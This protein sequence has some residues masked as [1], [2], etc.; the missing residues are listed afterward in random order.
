[1][2]FFWAIGATFEAVLAL[3]T[4]GPDLGWR[5]LVAISSLPLLVFLLLSRFL[6]ES[7]MFLAIT[8]QKDMVERQ[9]NEVARLNEKPAIHG[10]LVLD[11]EAA[12][13]ASRGRVADLFKG[14][15]GHEAK[16]TTMVLFLWFV[17]ANMYYGVVLTSTE[18]LNSSADTCV[19]GAGSPNRGTI[20]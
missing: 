16:L 11:E 18:L 9:L 5:Y 20:Q 17:T 4:M 13:S 2:A 12:S 19:S 1:M 14:P 3:L 15:I 10:N 8:G 6:P 7:L